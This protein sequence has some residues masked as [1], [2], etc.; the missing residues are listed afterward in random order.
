MMPNERQ[1]RFSQPF[2][3]AI[4]SERNQKYEVASG[5]YLKEA[6]NLQE[7]KDLEGSAFCFMLAGQSKRRA[8]KNAREEFEKAGTIYLEI[9]DRIKDTSPSNSRMAYRCAAKCFLR[10]ELYDRAREAQQF[11]YSIKKVSGPEDQI[12]Q[13]IMIVDDSKVVTLKLKKYVTEFGFQNITV[14]NSG[15][16]GIEKF[17]KLISNNQFPI[18]LLD[19]S[20]PDIT[21]KEVAS[22]M[23]AIRPETTI[24]LITADGIDSDRVR[25]ALANGV[26]YFLQKPFRYDEIRELL[27]TMQYEERVA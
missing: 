5:L 26:G 9:A 22:Q 8:E 18:V 19:M 1:R 25:E 15:K 10:A 12:K 17:N 3:D 4:R 24:A 7:K 27:E 11:A 21:G 23:L 14:C 16:E 2:L 20:M 6:A 13:P